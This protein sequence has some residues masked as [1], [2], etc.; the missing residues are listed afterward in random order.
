V[1]FL[2][3]LSLGIA[4]TMG[5]IASLCA[6]IRSLRAWALSICVLSVL[7]FVATVSWLRPF[8]IAPREALMSAL[9]ILPLGAAFLFPLGVMVRRGASTRSVFVAAFVLSAVAVPL[10]V[11]W[12]IYLSCTGGWDCL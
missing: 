1:Q 10:W 9:S 8:R 12:D 4:V 2:L 11:A 7:G 6:R 3:V 5:G